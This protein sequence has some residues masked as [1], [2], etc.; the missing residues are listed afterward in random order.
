M[1]HSFLSIKR[2]LLV[3]SLILLSLSFI[4]S[5]Q[6]LK[7]CF[8]HLSNIAK[9]HPFL[10]VPAAKLLVH[11]LA[12]ISRLDYCSL[13]LAGLHLSHLHALISIQKSSVR[14]TFLHSH[15]FDHMMPL[16]KS[17]HWFPILSRI[18]HN[19][20][21]LTFEALH[22]LA[23]PSLSSL[24]SSWFPSVPF[25]LPPLSL[26]SLPK[27]PAPLAGYVPFFLLPLTLGTLSLL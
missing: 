10:S 9:I 3:L 17:L 16:L 7:S 18:Q 11:L 21:V 2:K 27:S 4:T 8:F 6:L 25:A 15:G 1:S 26:S 14:I 23:P 12:V 24:S 20:L 5:N 13:L 22:G 19:L